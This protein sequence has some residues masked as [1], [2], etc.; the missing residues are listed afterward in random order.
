MNTASTG[1]IQSTDPHQE[2][3]SLSP[4]VPRRL[5]RGPDTAEY[6]TGAV[7]GYCSYECYSSH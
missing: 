5:R 6:D 2:D 4:P 7:C 1:T 3:Q